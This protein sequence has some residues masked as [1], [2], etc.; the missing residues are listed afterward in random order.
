MGLCV[1]T[2]F[3]MGFLDL[4]GLDIQGTPDERDKRSLAE[5]AALE[6]SDRMVKPTQE[7]TE[8][9]LRLHEKNVE[10]VRGFR[11]EDQ[12]KLLDPTRVGVVLSER[13]FLFRL[14]RILPVKV[15]D[16]TARGMRGL[17]AWKNGR[18][19]YVCAVQC[20]YAPEFSLMNYNDYWLPTTEKYRGWRGTVLL[21][22]ILGGYITE[23]AA[24]KEFGKPVANSA[25]VIYRKKLYEYRNRKETKD[26]RGN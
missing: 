24:H 3:F 10:R 26:G 5:V 2:P 21:R 22:L 9:Y 17:S 18:Y 7:T 15:N 4:T 13:E 20:G 14:G 19:E 1:T 12:D 6:A 25:S 16:W 8:L 23:T 11:W